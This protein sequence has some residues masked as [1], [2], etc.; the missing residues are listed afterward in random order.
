MRRDIYKEYLAKVLINIID[1]SERAKHKFMSCLPQLSEIKRH[2]SVIEVRAECYPVSLRELMYDRVQLE[3][4]GRLIVRSI[5]GALLEIQQLDIVIRNI[6]A[7]TVILGASLDKA[8]FTDL[9]RIC[10]H[11]ERDMLDCLAPHPYDKE[12]AKLDV[13]L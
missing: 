1:F 13:W 6:S 10:E 11:S 9:R 7:F 4:K 5:L 12:E 2:F 3:K 8:M